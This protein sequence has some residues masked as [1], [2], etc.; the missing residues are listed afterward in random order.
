MLKKQGVILDKKG[1]KNTTPTW[2]ITNS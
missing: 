2:K 1:K